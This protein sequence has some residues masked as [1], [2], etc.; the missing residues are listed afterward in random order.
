MLV[1]PGPSALDMT[2][3]VLLYHPFCHMLLLFLSISFHSP[4]CK[5]EVIWTHQKQWTC[6]P[7]SRKWKYKPFQKSRKDFSHMGDQLPHEFEMMRGD[8]FGKTPE[9]SNSGWI[10]RQCRIPVE[11]PTCLGE[12][13]GCSGRIRREG[14]VWKEWRCGVL[15]VDE[16]R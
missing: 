9:L 14:V 13:S 15:W 3:V 8:G 12:A 16:T 6:W 10:I 5:E 1:R 11:L 7:L 2:C 4:F